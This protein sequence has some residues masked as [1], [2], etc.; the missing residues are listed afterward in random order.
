VS[1]P[2]F[3]PSF[4]LSLSKFNLRVLARLEKHLNQLHPARV[5]ADGNNFTGLS[6]DSASFPAISGI[7]EDTSGGGGGEEKRERRER[8]RERGM[9]NVSAARSGRDPDDPSINENQA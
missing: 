2:S 6:R 8:E 7:Y 9:A 4:S 5:I 3:S 1:L